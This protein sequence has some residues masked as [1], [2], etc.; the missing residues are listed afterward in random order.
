MSSWLFL[1]RALMLLS[2]AHILLVRKF[3]FLWMS[4]NDRKSWKR[5]KHQKGGGMSREIVWRNH[6]DFVIFLIIPNQ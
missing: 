1:V 4:E 2:N 6:M 3:L 5:T